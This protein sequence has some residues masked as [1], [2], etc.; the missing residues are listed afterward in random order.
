M[1]AGNVHMTRKQGE[2]HTCAADI[3]GE[4]EGEEGGDPASEGRGEGVLAFL[5]DGTLIHNTDSGDWVG[6]KGDTHPWSPQQT[7]P[8]I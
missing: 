5:E 3:G 2:G 6:M 1:R 4:G 7:G 8:G